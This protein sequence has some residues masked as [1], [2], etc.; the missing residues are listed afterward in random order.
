[1]GPTSSYAS[2]ERGP[3]CQS[4]SEVTSYV[5]MHNSLNALAFDC[6]GEAASEVHDV[7]GLEALLIVLDK[8]EHRLGYVTQPER[9][10]A[11][12]QKIEAKI[13][14]VHQ[15]RAKGTSDKKG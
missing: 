4:I 3:P 5:H 6:V 11:A 2:P 9:L 10:A 1:M 13:A 8:L 15:A 14:A 7:A 12:R